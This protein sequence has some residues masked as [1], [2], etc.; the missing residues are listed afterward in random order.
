[1][2]NFME[3]KKKDKTV[4]LKEWDGNGILCNTVK[5]WF[6]EACLRVLEI[7]AEREEIIA[8]IEEIDGDRSLE[9]AEELWVENKRSE[10]FEKA[11]K[12]FKA[13]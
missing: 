8:F 5:R 7:T 4:L 10:I 2:E 1:M 13:A 3:Y 12:F 6:I 9:E 11:A